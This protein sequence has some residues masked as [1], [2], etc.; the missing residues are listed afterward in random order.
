MLFLKIRQQIWIFLLFLLNKGPGACW[1]VFFLASSFGLIKIISSYKQLLPWLYSQITAVTIAIKKED[2][3]QGSE[4][5]DCH[6][7]QQ[8]AVCKGK[9]RQK[10]QIHSQGTEG[11]TVRACP[12]PAASTPPFP[13]QAAGGL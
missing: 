1:P 7:Q 10:K 11:G 4:A 6:G 9:K 5:Q 2:E 12:Q 13:E 3:N 8:T